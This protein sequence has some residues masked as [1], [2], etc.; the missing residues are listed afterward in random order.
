M[1]IKYV[2]ILLIISTF[3][4]H[5]QW[6]QLNNPFGKRIT[7]LFV[8][9]GS[10]YVSTDSN[11]VY[12]S[13][14]NGQNW[15]QR[16]TGITKLRVLSLTKKN[17]TL[18]VGTYGGGVFISTNDGL[19]WSASTTGMTLP[20]IY[21]LLITNANDYILAG[22]GGYGAYISSD[23]G[24]SWNTCLST[25]Y[26]ILDFYHT[27]NGYYLCAAGPRLYKSTDEGLNWTQLVTGNTTL[28]SIL[29]TSN[30]QGGMNI[31]VG[32]LDGMFLSTNEGANW[33]VIN[34]GIEYRD[35]P[36]LASIDSYVFAAS[37]S[38]GGVYLT[39]NNG[40][41]WGQINTGLTDLEIQRIFIDGG[42]I[43]AGS[44]TGVVFRREL[45]QVITS[46]ET[47][48]YI[49][50]DFNLNQN[51]PNP[52]NPSTRISWQVPIGSHQTLKVYDILGNEVATLVDEYRD[53]G[54]YEVE[55]NVEQT[56]SL[57]SG[58]YFYK[59]QAGDYVQIKKMM[60][61]K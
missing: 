47:E 42:Y 28:K 14:D 32:S 50:Y 19:S 11:G 12:Y 60:L 5:A 61:M 2:T 22:S 23:G 7:G 54:S 3:Q 27:L 8:S 55:F 38:G 33:S 17:N 6:I 20:Y 13:G 16:N 30:G 41:S 29:T 24:S 43:Y 31:F 44:R 56:T 37:A 4:T 40:Q 1:K 15:A 59:L 45:S 36:S 39:T 9:N 10:I 51:Y 18:A 25:T 35:I 53:A 52:F 34:N 21:S 57:S 49:S 26:I 58:V 46:A 48:Y